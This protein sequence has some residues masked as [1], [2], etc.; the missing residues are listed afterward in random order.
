MTNYEYSQMSRY[1]FLTHLV[2]LYL[3]QASLEAIN[4]SGSSEEDAMYLSDRCNYLC[5][6]IPPAKNLISGKDYYN[7]LIEAGFTTLTASWFLSKECRDQFIATKKA[8]GSKDYWE[9]YTK[10]YAIY[11]KFFMESWQK[12]LGY[13]PLDKDFQLRYKIG[14]RNYRRNEENNSLK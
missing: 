8:Y 13:E 5:T 7:L 12:R 14:Y 3:T 6:I 10:W 9:V 2:E 1:D 11:L 4:E